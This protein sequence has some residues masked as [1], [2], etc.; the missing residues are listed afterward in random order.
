MRHATWNAVRALLPNPD[1]PEVAS[2]AA[3]DFGLLGSGDASESDSLT[4]HGA[5]LLLKGHP[6]ALPTCPACADLVDLALLIRAEAEQAKYDAEREA[7]AAARR[8]TA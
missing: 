1:A 5:T 7:E 4:L 6:A 2:V 8:K 3:C